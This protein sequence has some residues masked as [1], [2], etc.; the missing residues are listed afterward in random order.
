V[1]GDRA[2]RGNN[3]AAFLGTAKRRNQWKIVCPMTV[4]MWRE[5]E[6][7]RLADSTRRRGYVEQNALRAQW[8][9]LDRQISDATY[10]VDAAADALRAS[11][12]RVVKN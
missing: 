3:G 11:A 7:R 6:Y 10:R 9:I 12:R 8:E 1:R 5:D 2:G 4:I